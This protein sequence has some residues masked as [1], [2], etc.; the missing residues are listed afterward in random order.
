[1][2]PRNKPDDAAADSKS[3]DTAADS[4]PANPNI[5]DVLRP[6]Q[7]AAMRFVQANVSARDAAMRESAQACLDLQDQVRRVEQD[8]QGAFIEGTRKYLDRLAQQTTGSPEEMYSA[9]LQAQ[10]DYEKELQQIAVDRDAKLRAAMQSASEQAGN[11]DPVKKIA[12]RRQE[13]YQTY[14]TD[15]QK[16]WSSVPTA[17]PQTV[18][19]IATHILTTINMA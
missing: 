8:A 10:S 17:D 9:R 19:T 16:A 2:A 14:V 13:A 12:D 4:R 3:G 18:N 7:D 11:A 15:L 1:M 6:F 5:E